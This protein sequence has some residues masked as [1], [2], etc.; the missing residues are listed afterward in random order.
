VSV[1]L[2]GVI[3]SDYGGECGTYSD[4]PAVKGR[5]LGN[6]KKY[7]AAVAEID[8]RGFQM[9]RRLS[10]TMTV[11]TAMDAYENAE[12]GTTSAIAGRGNRNKLKHQAIRLTRFGKLGVIARMSRCTPIRTR[13]LLM[14]RAP[15]RRPGARFQRHG[16]E[17][18]LR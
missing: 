17:E 14:S 5:C 7:K 9:L 4:D 1:R 16:V 11:R 13:T 12:S 18:H 10:E 3:E 8:R 6:P 15:K 2:D